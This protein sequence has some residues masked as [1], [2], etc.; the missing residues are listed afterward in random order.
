MKIRNIEKLQGQVSEFPVPEWNLI[1]WSQWCL[2]LRQKV[3]TL[4][5]PG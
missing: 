4:N 2:H 3:D 1:S 5:T